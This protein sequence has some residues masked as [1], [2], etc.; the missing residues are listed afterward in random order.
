[1]YLDNDEIYSNRDYLYK[2]KK[3]NYPENFY[4]NEDKRQINYYLD[5]KK[6]IK[7]CNKYL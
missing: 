4:L 1:M 2:H 7:K 3:K 5:K 6:E